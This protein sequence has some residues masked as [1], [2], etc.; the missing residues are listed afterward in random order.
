M[1]DL[2]DGLPQSAL[3]WSWLN[4]MELANQNRFSRSDLA[5][6]N[7]EPGLIRD[8][9]LQNIKR[10]FVPGS[11]IKKTRIGSQHIGLLFQCI[12]AFVH[13]AHS[14]FANAHRLSCLLPRVALVE[15]S[16]IAV[17]VLAL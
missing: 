11:E 5:T 17:C 2:W 3:V 14:N 13:P 1:P 12:I 10:S 8:A 4:I 7:D 15:F 6:N 16:I 9:T